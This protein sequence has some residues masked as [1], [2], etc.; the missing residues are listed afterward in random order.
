MKVFPRDQRF[1]RRTHNVE[2]N[3]ALS[4]WPLQL[5]HI[6]ETADKDFFHRNRVRRLS[7]Q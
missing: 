5:R 7:I 2:E 1:S 3:L 6:L 4:P